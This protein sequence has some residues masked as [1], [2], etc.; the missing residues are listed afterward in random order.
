MTSMKLRNMY[1][2]KRGLGIILAFP[3]LLFCISVSAWGQVPYTIN[4]QGYLTDSSGNPVDGTVEVTFSLYG[5]ASGGDALWSEIQSVAVANGVY[6]VVLGDSSPLDA[7]SFEFP[8]YLGVKVSEDDEMIPRLRLTSVPYALT[9]ET[10]GDART[11]EGHHAD[12]FSL[13]WHNHDS[14]YVNEGQTNA[15]TTAMIENGAISDD[16]ITGPIIGSKISSSGLDADTVD[17]R[18]A[19][20]L[21]DR[22]IGQCTDGS[23]IGVIHADG[24]VECESDDDTTYSA[25]TGVTLSEN[26][27]ALDKAY[28]NGS[29]YDSRFLNTSGDTV[30]GDLTVN[31][32]IDTGGA[33]KLGGEAILS[34]LSSNIF[35]GKY[36]GAHNTSGNENTF[37]GHAA[38]NKNITAG[39]NTFVGAYSGNDNTAGEANTFVGFYSGYDN[40]S[41]SSNTFVGHWAGRFNEDGNNNTFLGYHAGNDNHTGSGNVF[42][43]YSAG[44]RE[45]G[46]DKLFI[47]NSDT[48]DP[49]IW[50][51][52]AADVLAVNGRLG[53]GTHP[54]EEYQFHCKDARQTGRAVYGEATGNGSIGVWGR[55]TEGS[56]STGVW[57]E[58]SKWDFYANGTGS[59]Y[60]PFTGAHEVKLGPGVPEDIRPGMILSVTGETAARKN[61][62]GNIL[63]SSTL[64]TVTLSEKATDKALFGVFISEGPLPEGHWYEASEG[65]RFGI[66]NALGE[67]R[68][69][70]SNINGD[71]GAGDYI[72]S[73]PVPGYGQLQEDD[74]LHSY[75]L[76]KATEAV[77]WDTVSETVEY[78]GRAVKVYLI[79]VV[80]TSG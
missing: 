18:H 58:G 11:V 4:F 38:G 57:G 6:N 43:G 79:A 74:I 21:Q 35:V 72:T 32:D 78:Q 15:I 25:G 28:A 49:L 40:L 50:G 48:L 22:V 34:A 1:F 14:T 73:S 7:L 20:D 27:F 24:T 13:I 61:T 10:A 54:G 76:G 31:G 75:T 23:S 60:G 64:P 9:A 12:E 19:A 44:F 3:T 36:A 62:Q 8:Y 56:N 45:T 2:G 65:E 17:G 71:V 16:K 55:A 47:D 42:V 68:V 30:T 80:Y 52:F 63:L 77:D 69:W 46:S 29:A 51:D 59:N 37:I 53:V 66:V 41:G 70:V 26:T 67:G 5:V 33:Y 39:Y